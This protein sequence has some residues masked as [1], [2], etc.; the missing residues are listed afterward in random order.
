[1]CNASKLWCRMYL[2]KVKVFHDVDKGESEVD[3]AM[4]YRT[5]LSLWAVRDLFVICNITA[6]VPPVEL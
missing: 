6:G 2:M 5:H 3:R 4:V 1:M